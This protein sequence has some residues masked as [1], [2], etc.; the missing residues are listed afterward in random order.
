MD[1][2]H[3]YETW[4]GYILNISDKNISFAQ[5]D[6]RLEGSLLYMT[7]SYKES[8]LG[9]THFDSIYG[10][11]TVP[12]IVMWIRS[13]PPG[14]FSGMIRKALFPRK[15]MFFV[16]LARSTNARTSF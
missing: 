5:N 1:N 8:C 2:I 13:H 4:A 3:A 12:E 6:I 9:P 10:G 11:A 7:D 15:Q 14:C 16:R